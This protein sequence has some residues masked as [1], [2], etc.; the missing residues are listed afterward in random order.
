MISVLS[1]GFP[2]SCIICFPPVQASLY[3][4][5]LWNGDPEGGASG[6][7]DQSLV[8]SDQHCQSPPLV[9]ISRRAQTRPVGF[10]DGGQR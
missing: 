2:V 1:F 5:S 3:L 9:E 6:G 7:D 8:R 10:H 4:G